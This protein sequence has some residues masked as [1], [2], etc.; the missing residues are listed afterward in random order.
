MVTGGIFAGWHYMQPKLV[1]Y[2]AEN[3]TEMKFKTDGDRFMEYGPD[4][5]WRE[6]FVKVSTWAQLHLDITR[7]IPVN[8]RGLLAMVPAD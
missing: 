7:R 5:T 8:Q 1:T 3:G 2:T 6:M 4:G